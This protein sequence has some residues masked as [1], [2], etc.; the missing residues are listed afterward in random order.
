V[1]VQSHWFAVGQDVPWAEAGVGVIATQSFTN[2]A[3]GLFGLDLMRSGRSA[4][5]AMKSLLARDQGRDVRQVAMVDAKGQVAVHTGPKC[6]Q[7]AGHLVGKE[8][9]VQA[10]LMVNDKVWPAMARA[11]ESARGDLAERM[12]VALEAAQAAGGDLR[13]KQ[14]AAMLVV[15]G[16]ST[17][18]PWA[19]RVFNLRV[20][21]H[22][23]PLKELRRL[24]TLQ[25]AYRLMNEGDLLME[26]R[27]FAGA[28][29]AYAA[30]ERLATDNLEMV[31]W[32]AVALVNMNKVDE[33]LP[34][35]RRAFAGSPE[36]RTLVTRLPK[37]GL[38]PE[39]PKLLERITAP[40]PPA[41][42]RRP[43][44]AAGGG[45]R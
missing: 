2:P 34:L 45:K 20:E 36:W 7:A 17:G 1:A 38:L 18:R 11:F 10:N 22:P 13:G 9:A 14:S 35:F 24:T 26:K 32:H 15:G 31:F 3:Y 25:R 6:I 5:E 12:L 33:A 27:D 37:A 44:P 42:D 41:G 40:E 29:N 39:D 28:L 19:D 4:P 30:A 21:D 16:K 23:D 8:Y 43:A